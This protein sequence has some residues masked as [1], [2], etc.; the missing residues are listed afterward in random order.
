[1]SSNTVELYRV[2]YTAY[3]VTRGHVRHPIII[4]LLAEKLGYDM[5]DTSK[6]QFLVE[7]FVH[8]ENELLF[9]KERFGVVIS[10]DGISEVE[11]TLLEPEKP[12]RFFPPNVRRFA[13]V[14]EYLIENVRTAKKSRQDFLYCAHED[15][16]G[17]ET[18]VVSPFQIKQKLGLEQDVYERV[19]FYLI[20][21]GLI[22]TVHSNGITITHKAKLEIGHKI[23]GK[24]DESFWQSPIP[25]ITI[26][27]D[28]V[29]TLDKIN[30]E[31]NTKF[32]WEIFYNK[33][34]PVRELRIAIANLNNDSKNK[35]AFIS[36]LLAIATILGDINTKDI[37]ALVTTKGIKGFKMIQELFD[38]KGIE[39][40]ESDF[41]IVR[42]VIRLRSTILP[43]H[44]AETEFSQVLRSV[45]IPYPV[46]D[47]AQAADT[48]LTHVLEGL[49]GLLE[50]LS[51]SV[52]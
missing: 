26:S 50:K 46:I 49:N 2:L 1:M 28:I 25:D 38:L 34:G 20:D 8:L 7:L 17:F 21:D 48:C 6:Y 42:K 47:W 14:D 33:A 44:S 43:V 24:S 30:T 39:Y 13:Q 10:I 32:G 23:N 31:F 35:A 45:G 52:E 18:T 36:C 37:G 27:D 11:K 16:N 41:I 3:E 22:K 12:T 5:N 40:D 4:Q 29:H 9:R 19:Y 15:A 51:S